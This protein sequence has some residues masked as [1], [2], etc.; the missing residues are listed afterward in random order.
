MTKHQIVAVVS[1]VV[2]TCSLYFFVDTKPKK[3]AKQD[4]STNIGDQS[5]TFDQIIINQKDSLSVVAKKEIDSLEQ[6]LK[7]A[8]TDSVRVDILKRLSSIWYTEGKSLVSGWYAEKV[9]QKVNTAEAWQIAGTTYRFA[10]QNDRDEKLREIS[11]QRASKTLENA[12]KLDSSNI[13]YKIQLAMVYVDRPLQ[14]NPMKG[15]LML[16]E[17]DSKYPNQPAV[18]IQLGQLAMKTAQ[19]DKAIERF[20]KA[21]ALLP[22]ET[23]IYCMLADAYTGKGDNAAA[24]EVAKKCKK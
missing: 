24:I 11:S 19:Y 2:L 3:L 5:S 7:A 8:T 20:K 23:K 12:I 13:A 16:R 6:S 21:V 4:V 22:N 14:E 18:I 9:A 15:I 1:A 17:L 10:L